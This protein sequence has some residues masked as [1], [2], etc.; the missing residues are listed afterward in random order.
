MKYGRK[1]NLTTKSR[2]DISE[3]EVLNSVEVIQLL[4]GGGE[5][6]SKAKQLKST[7]NNLVYE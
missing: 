1:A 4:A 5:G 3:L 2:S 6:A 7:K